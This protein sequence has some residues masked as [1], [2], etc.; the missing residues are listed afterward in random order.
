[1]TR[2]FD[3]EELEAL[4]LRAFGEDVRIDRSVLFFEPGAVRIGSHVRI[5][6][7]CVITGEAAASISI[8]DHVHLS[9]GVYL[10]GGGG[11]EIADHVGLSSRVAVYSVNDDYSGSAMTGPT[12]PDELRNVH[13]APVK[14]GSHVVV[15]SGSIVLPGVVIGEGAIVGALSLVKR[16]VEPFTMVAGNPLRYIRPR[17]RTFLELEPRVPR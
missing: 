8:G 10:F 2:N 7:Q 16:S 17:K 15:G 6:V 13:R 1:M 11:I 12:L 4:G 3:R 14:I 9:C 5:D